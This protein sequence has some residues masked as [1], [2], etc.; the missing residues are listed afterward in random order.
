MAQAARR[1]GRGQAGGTEG[2][3]QRRAEESSGGCDAGRAQGRPEG[4]QLVLGW[5]TMW[6]RFSE[7]CTNLDP[8]HAEASVHSAIPCPWPA[9][10]V[11]VRTCVLPYCSS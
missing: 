6:F 11:C 10:C 8:V 3:A 1:G 7:S 5:G 2:G 9:L 4:P